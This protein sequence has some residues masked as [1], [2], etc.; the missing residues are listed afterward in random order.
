MDG[1]LQLSLKDIKCLAE[2][3]INQDHCQCMVPCTV[4]LKKVPTFKLS[5]TLSN[6]NQLSKCVHCSKAHELCYK[7]LRIAH[8]TLGTLLGC[9]G[10]LKIYI[11]CRY[12]ADMEENAKKLHVIASNFVIHPQILI[13]FGV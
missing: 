1:P 13:F 2:G 5:V 6:L 11:Y 9:L 7:T 4:C 10:K 3:S 12:S 8:L